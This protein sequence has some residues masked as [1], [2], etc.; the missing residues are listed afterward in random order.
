MSPRITS[1]ERDT[2]LAAL[3]AWQ[4]TPRVRLAYYHLATNGGQT[5]PLTDAEIDALCRRL[6]IPMEAD[7]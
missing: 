7:C 2:I 5:P 1:N 3:R 4:A 6:D